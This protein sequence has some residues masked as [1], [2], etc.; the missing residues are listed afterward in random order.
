MLIF[1]NITNAFTVTL[2]QFNATEQNDLKLHLK[3][4]LTPN[5]WMVVYQNSN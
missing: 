1:Y 5:F 3:I 4:L 2:E